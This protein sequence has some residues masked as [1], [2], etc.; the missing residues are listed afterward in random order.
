MVSKA[1]F[2][3]PYLVF[4]GEIVTKRMFQ[5]GLSY[6]FQLV[7]IG[8]AADVR[9]RRISARQRGPPALVLPR[10]PPVELL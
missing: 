9:P 10:V 1:T 7:T 3:F 5:R 2:S 6:T 4:G 8:A